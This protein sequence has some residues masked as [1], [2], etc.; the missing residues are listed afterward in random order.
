MKYL[1]IAILFLVIIPGLI[2]TVSTLALMDLY[3]FL[4][5][6][7]STINVTSGRSPSYPYWSGP[8]ELVE[9]NG[10]GIIMTTFGITFLVS[11][12]LFYAYTGI[13]VRGLISFIVGIALVTIGSA[14]VLC[15][16]NEINLY[17]GSHTLIMPPWDK[18]FPMI[19]FILMMCPFKLLLF[20]QLA[21]MIPSSGAGVI[22][23]TTI[24]FFSCRKTRESLNV[25]TLRAT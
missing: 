14:L 4:W 6:N 17:P 15:V 12:S 1:N 11:F 22:V 20:R 8:Y 2:I 16:I 24:R 10:T 3:G 18:W 5:A 13:S 9:A 25:H 19:N 7:E 21:L 23:F